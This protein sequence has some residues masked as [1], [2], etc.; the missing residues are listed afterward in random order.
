MSPMTILYFADIAT[1]L[2]VFLLTSGVVL[3]LFGFFVFIETDKFALKAKVLFIFVPIISIFIGI[4]IPGKNTIYMMFSVDALQQVAAT[5]E[6]KE[7]GSKILKLAN[8]K[9]DE[10]ISKK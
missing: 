4:L 6:A 2:S 8:Q 7:I 9:L 3:L 10:A 5:P 1:G